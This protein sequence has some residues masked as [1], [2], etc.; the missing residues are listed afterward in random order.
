M[1]VPGTRR[2]VDVFHHA[3]G[4]GNR[5][6]PK[7]WTRH[8]EKRRLEHIACRSRPDERH[9]PGWR[10]PKRQHRAVRASTHPTDRTLSE[11]LLL[12]T[13]TLRRPLGLNLKEEGT[14]IVIESIEKDSNADRCGAFA[15]GDT[16]VACSAIMMVHPDDTTGGT[17]YKKNSRGKKGGCCSTGCHDCP[18]NHRNWQRV[19]FDCRDKDFDTVI[20]ALQSNY[21]ARYVFEHDVTPKRALELDARPNALT[22][23]ALIRSFARQVAGWWRGQGRDDHHFRGEIVGG[24]RYLD[25]ETCIHSF[26]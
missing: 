7:A 17:L 21:Q 5:I 3:L 4:F 12:R 22:R 18:F 24:N 16:L 10:K 9:I 13:A 20:A 11:D 25:I 8:E 1:D 14:R 6:T 23:H 2:V 19:M 15:V 26:H